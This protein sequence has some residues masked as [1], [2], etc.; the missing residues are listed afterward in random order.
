MWNPCIGDAGKRRR[1]EEINV[2]I[3]GTEN[4]AETHTE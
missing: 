4:T 2:Q 3:E 1:L